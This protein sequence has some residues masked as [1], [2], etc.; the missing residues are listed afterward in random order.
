M[1]RDKRRENLQLKS[2]TG[3]GTRS[4][5]LIDQCVGRK[6][7]GGWNYTTRRPESHT[8]RRR[9]LSVTYKYIPGSSQELETER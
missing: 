6:K 3:H 2:L 8:P 9:D 5:A 1:G 7:P 4:I